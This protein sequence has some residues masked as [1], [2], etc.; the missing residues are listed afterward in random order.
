MAGN[1][2]KEDLRRGYQ[3]QLDL[4]PE[5]YMQGFQVHAVS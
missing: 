2:C 4:Y 1:P 3:F 5:I